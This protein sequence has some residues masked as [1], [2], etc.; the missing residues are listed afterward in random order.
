MD[1]ALLYGKDETTRIVNISEKDN[2]LYIYRELEDHTIVC[3]KRPAKYSMLFPVKKSPKFRKLKGNG[4]YRYY[5]EY[6]DVDRFREVKSNCYRKKLR[7][8]SPHTAVNHSMLYDGLSYFTDMKR[9]EV[10]ELFFDIEGI[11]LLSHKE[12]RTLIIDNIYRF[13]GKTI[14]KA[15]YYD[16]YESDKD[17][18]D[19]WCNWIRKMDPSIMIAYNEFGYDLPYLNLCAKK[20]MTELCL[21]RDGSP[22]EISERVRKFRKDGSQT[23]DFNDI[24][25]HGREVIDAM[26]LAINGDVGRKYP[27]YK[28][29]EII[30]FEGL[31][32]KDRQFY[33]ASLIGKNYKKPKEWK[34]IKAY[35]KDDAW[36]CMQVYDL[37]SPSVFYYTQ[38]IPMTFQNINNSATGSQVNSFMIRA[39]YQQDYSLPKASEAEEY[40]GAISFGR[41]GVY[42]SVAK[43]DVASLYPSIMRHYKVYN[44]RKDPAKYFLNM[45]EY[46]TIERLKNKKLAK[47]TRDR[48]Y[49]DL[50]ASQKIVI[51][52]AYGFLGTEGCLF[53]FPKGAAFVTAKGRQILMKGIEWACGREVEL[54]ISEVRNQGT[55]DEETKYKYVLGDCIPNCKHKGYEIVNVDTDSFSYTTSLNSKYKTKN[56][57]TGLSPFDQDIEDLNS[58]FPELISWE[59]D[60]FYKTVV[61]LKTKNYILD[62][63]KKVIIKGNSLKATNKEPALKQFIRDVVDILLKNKTEHFIHIYQ[64]YAA[65]ILNVTD[66]AKWCFKKTVTKNFMTSDR[67]N[68][69]LPWNAIKH[70]K[71]QEGDKVYLFFEDEKTYRLREEFKGEYSKKKLFGKLHSTAKTFNTLF[72]LSLVPNYSKAGNQD[73]LEDL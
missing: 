66:I 1:K 51:N 20:A 30:E 24:H 8:W 67:P 42:K 31:V 43:V 46:F 12:H 6:D 63:G 10:S 22:I 54:K 69:Q 23:Y 11:G 62:D 16:E 26:F 13:K 4:F 29:K 52:S 55:E 25:I 33:D 32:K 14:H 44:K 41:P 34:K 27:S 36:D 3:D 18:L 2:Q 65:E 40:E 45:V 61:V 28:L 9:D 38:H 70:T 15:F 71:P 68:E 72:D 35:C 48:F 73:L 39:Y 50:Q 60:G 59:N 7:F 64:K 57:E 53:N 49:D 47:E 19:A 58:L 56:K 37:Y 5:M 21:G 17:F